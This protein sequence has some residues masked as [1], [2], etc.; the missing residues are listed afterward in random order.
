MATKI[1]KTLTHATKSASKDNSAYYTS[2]AAKKNAKSNSGFGGGKT[3]G[4][5]AGRAEV[6]KKQQRKNMADL[7][8]RMGTFGYDY[9]VS[10]AV[11]KA[12]SKKK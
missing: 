3:S 5:G 1:K 7:A 2:D 6:K 8:L 12:K 4:G 10:E 11:K 9:V